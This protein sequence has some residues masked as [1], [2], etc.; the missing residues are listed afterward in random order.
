MCFSGGTQANPQATAT[1]QNSINNQAIVDTAKINQVNQVNPLGSSTW[2]GTP[3]QGDNTQTT[4]LN[5]QLQTILNGIQGAGVNA[6]GNIQTNP[7]DFSQLAGGANV[8]NDYAP[9]QDSYNMGGPVQYNIAGA[10]PVQ[11]QINTSGVPALNTDYAGQIKQAQDAAYNAQSQYLDPQFA[12]QQQQLTSQLAAQGIT[13]GSDAYNNAIKNF[14]ATKNQA[15]Q[16]AS[17]AAVSA[18]NQLQNQLFGQNLSANNQL[19]GQAAT[20]GN[21]T[22]SAQNQLFGQNATG[23]AFNN[24]AAAQDNSQ[25]AAAAQFANTA[26]TQKFD[27][28]QALRTQGLNEMQYA[29]NAPINQLMALLNGTSI[30]NVQFSPTTQ[31]NPAQ[32]SPDLVG[33]ANN[34]AKNNSSILGD[35]F[36]TVGKVGAAAVTCW[37]AREVFGADDP[38]WLRMRH[39]MLTK[40][41]VPLR[42]FY[43]EYGPAIADYIRDKPSLKTAIRTDMEAILGAQ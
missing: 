14:G 38:R 1:A 17:D 4:T 25:N 10:G 22:N 35:I 32:A 23:A 20:Q 37:V 42:D 33:T 12:Q 28:T 3:G 31:Y 8:A 29:N 21:F 11:S 43:L 24:A 30:G 26:N 5:P 34:N 13:Q 27:Q 41:P 36:G 15:Y 39:W 18:G 19:F 2:S 9:I 16:G 7:V 6:V 40:A